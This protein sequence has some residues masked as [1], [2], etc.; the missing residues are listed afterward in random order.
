MSESPSTI[1]T[2]V[3][4]EVGQAK[5]RYD[6]PAVAELGD[7]HRA[8]G[9]TPGCVSGSLPSFVCDAGG[10]PSAVPAD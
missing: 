10:Q 9:Q 8:Q 2:A 7:S 5:P 3:D 6:P 4:I 1:E